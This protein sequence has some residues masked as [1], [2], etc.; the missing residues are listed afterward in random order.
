MLAFLLGIQ[1]GKCVKI[2]LWI[3]CLQRKKYC[4]S[5]IWSFHKIWNFLGSNPGRMAM[6]KSHGLV[7]VAYTNKYLENV[8][9]IMSFLN[10]NSV[11][12]P[13]DLVS[14]MS[15]TYKPASQQIL[16]KPSSN[17]TQLSITALVLNLLVKKLNT[18]FFLGSWD[19]GSIGKCGWTT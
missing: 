2:S 12:H 7:S 16:I 18:G 8:W 15:S 13:N 1:L 5:I 9:I 3:Y 4:W 14:L 10:W 11:F 17:S 6:L 19:W